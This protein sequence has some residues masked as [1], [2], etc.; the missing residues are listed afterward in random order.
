M[1]IVIER[2]LEPPIQPYQFSGNFMFLNCATV[3]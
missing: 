3:H 2:S 1:P